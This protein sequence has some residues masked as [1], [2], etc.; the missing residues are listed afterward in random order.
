MRIALCTETLYPLFGVERR[1]YEMAKRLPKY[2]F[3]VEVLTSS[4]QHEVPDIKI[5]QVSF[6]TVTNP[7]KRSY[8]QCINFSA[9]IF[10][11]LAK[12]DYDI[13]DANGHLSLIPCSIAGI[14][15]KTPVI[16]TIH[17]LYLNEWGGMYGGI[18]AFAGLPL[19][20]IFCRMPYRKIITLNTSVRKKI[21][22]LGASG[23]IEII[24]SGIDIKEIGKIKSV[25]RSEN[26]ILYAGRLVPQKNIGMLIEAFK[27]LDVDAELV[28]VGNGSEYN[29]LKKM[30][31]GDAR[32]EFRGQLE[33]HDDVIMEMKAAG[34]LVMPS[35]RENFGIVPLEAMC[36]GAA[37]VSTRT[38]GPKD[39]IIDGDN[40]F[41]VNIGDVKSLADRMKMLLSDRNLRNKISM[42]GRKTAE[43][44]DWEEIVKRI[45]NLYKNL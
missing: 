11:S 5:K 26:R 12:D 10:R 15:K 37:V 8:A 32:I 29:K 4:F 43:K 24:P 2:G 44:Y 42:S 39:Y 30:A 34:I 35:S 18:G 19:E 7:P 38:E 23:K 16:A 25:E 31:S 41:L 6:P 3:D 22:M 9:N 20:I 33:S 14:A 17:D 40:G 27:M 1:V 13:I 45:A 36:C 28:I 21:E